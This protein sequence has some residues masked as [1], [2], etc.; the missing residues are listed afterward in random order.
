MQDLPLNGRNFVQLVQ[1]VPGANEG[2]GNGLTSGNR[3]DDRRQSSGFSVNG[4]DTTLNNYVI[5]GID[6]NERIIGTIGVKPS[7]EGI[8][9][10]SVQT[11]SYAPEAGRTAG[12]VVNIVTMAGSNAFHGSAYEYFRND[13]LDSRNVTSPAA[14]V[15]KAELRQ[16]QFG[17]S[18][19]GPIIK[20]K[21]FFFFDYEGLRQVQG[22]T[23]YTSTVPT[24]TQ[25][26]EINS[27][28][29]LS[30]QD[31]I[32]QGNLAGR[33]IRRPSSRTS[34]IRSLLTI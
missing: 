4:Q 31:L 11:N 23:T 9:E 20:N 24:I 19:G 3:P 29:G 25:Y 32:A 10:I 21:T 26:D 2:P 27:L 1:T 18:I 7:V 6:N 5:D 15:P 13:V 28:N 34:P 17:G 33:S 22:G 30:P 8:Q 12:G 14:S 16:N